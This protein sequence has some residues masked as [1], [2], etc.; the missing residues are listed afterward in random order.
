MDD[1]I[2]VLAVQ[3]EIAALESSGLELDEHALAWMERRAHALAA[4]RK[5]RAPA[6][7]AE[8][9]DRGVDGSRWG[10]R[11]GEAGHGKKSAPSGPAGGHDHQAR[12]GLD[13]DQEEVMS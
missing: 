1:E 3:D 13:T 10:A 6:A 12:K 7:L 5:D 11:G 9:G 2:V 8:Q 4:H